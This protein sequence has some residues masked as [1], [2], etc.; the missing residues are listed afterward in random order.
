MPRKIITEKMVYKF[1][2]LSESAKEK[3]LED[4][5]TD[6]EYFDG[7]E[8]IGGL[9]KLADA[10]GGRMVDYSIDW[11]ETYRT[12]VKFDMPELLIEYDPENDDPANKEEAEYN[13]KEFEKTLES[14]GAYDPKTLKGDGDCKLTGTWVDDVMIDAVRIGY[15]K[16]GIIDLNELMQD[17]VHAINKATQE[18]IQYQCG[19]EGFKETCDANDWKFNEDG[20]MA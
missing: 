19:E 4:Y 9:K 7:E 2:E 16:G 8:V 13:K 1:E 3:A 5:F 12:N 11:Y 15:K 18:D 20:S 14:L 6:F 17:A 10:L